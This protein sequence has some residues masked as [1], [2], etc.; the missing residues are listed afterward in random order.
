MAGKQS[1]KAALLV[2]KKVWTPIIAPALF[3][4]QQIGEMHLTE[5]QS[6]VGRK[7]TVSL[8]VL[9]GDP[10]RQNVH[11][12]FEVA[13]QENGQ[14]LTKVHGFSITPVAVR[15]MMRRGRDRIDDSF[16]AKTADGIPV[17]AKPVLIT[18]ARAKG[19]V[20]ADLRNQLRLN[21]IRAINKRTFLDFITDLVAHKYQRE[22][23]DT[24][25]KIYPLQVCEIRDVHI[26]TSEAAQKKILTAPP[27]PVAQPP[28]EPQAAAE[29]AAEPAEETR[30]APEQQ[31]EGV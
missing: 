4:N 14:L 6:A 15:K 24:L 1:S 13:K 28:A 11:I 29:S 2:K 27:A 10:Q 18:R 22:L 9:L 23:Q 26:D 17:R 20:L 3:N 25:R 16:M 30:A 8:M 31:P 21:V 7:V 12:T 5:D 19:G